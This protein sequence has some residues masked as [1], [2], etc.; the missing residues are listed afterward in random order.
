MKCQQAEELLGRFLD[1]PGEL[2]AREFAAV[3]EHVRSCSACGAHLEQLRWVIAQLEAQPQPKAPPDLA[4]KLHLRLASEP[5]PARIR[6]VDRL[7]GAFNWP[8]V[9]SGALVAAAVMFYVLRGM[10]PSVGIQVAAVPVDQNVGVQIAFDVGQDVKGVTFD[11][12]LSDGLRFVDA[13]G[14]P[15]DTQEVKWQGELLRGK[16]VVPVTVRGVRPGKWEILAVVRKD[17]MARATQIIVPVQAG[18]T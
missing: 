3:G 13:K 15:V 5:A 7:R 12:K 16:T 6:M 1:G 17:Q 4:A 2:P 14:Q 8:S 9:A 10:Q 18:Q 11:I